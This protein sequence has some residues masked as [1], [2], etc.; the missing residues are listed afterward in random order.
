MNYDKER[1]S[2]I[3]TGIGFGFLIGLLS[4]VLSI[5][6]YIFSI[7]PSWIEPESNL[8][9]VGMTSDDGRMRPTSLRSL[10]VIAESPGVTSMGYLGFEQTLV[11]YGQSSQVR[12]ALLIDPKLIRKLGLEYLLQSEREFNQRV[13][14][15][16][17][18]HKEFSESSERI[19]YIGD[20][21]IP[22]QLS[23][24]FPSE[25]SGL[26]SW[27]PDIIISTQHAENLVRINFNIEN[28]SL[29]VVSR[30]KRQLSLENP[31]FFG[32]AELAPGFSPSDLNYS[33]TKG[34]NTPNINIVSGIENLTPYYYRGFELNPNEKES[35]K[36]QWWLMLYL[37]IFLCIAVCLSYVSQT[38]S[39]NIKNI[40][41]T[42][43][44][45]ALGAQRLHIIKENL[46]KDLPVIIQAITFGVVFS[47]IFISLYTYNIPAVQI[48]WSVILI[49]CVTGAA[50]VSLIVIVLSILS[51]LQT[52]TAKLFNRD[53][54]RLLDGKARSFYLINT[55]C[56]FIF[57]GVALVISVYLMLGLVNLILQKEFAPDVMSSSFARNP[58]F[59]SSVDINPQM[60][61]QYED[62]RFAIATMNVISP[63]SLMTQV[64]QNYPANRSDTVVNV[65]S[66]SKSF[67]EI[68]GREFIVGREPRGA[69][70]VV[71]RSASA[72]LGF[73]SPLEAINKRIHIDNS[74]ILG[75]E[76]MDQVVISGVVEDIPHY[77]YLASGQPFIYGPIELLKSVPS[78]S[79]FA[80]KDDLA[81]SEEL[82]LN[83]SQP[84]I[85][86]N[87]IGNGRVINQF[88]KASQEAI[89]IVLISIFISL[90]IS[91]FATLSLRKQNSAILNLESVVIGTKLAIG[92]SKTNAF[93]EFAKPL[94]MWSAFSVLFYIPISFFIT[95]LLFDSMILFQFFIACII[96]III[97][98][99]IGV[100]G[101]VM[102]FIQLVSRSPNSLIKG[103]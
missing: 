33:E 17:E 98:L 93:L 62:G 51:T 37:T 26:G 36:Q 79:I 90:I 100:I 8:T 73:E 96:A 65:K 34:T 24:T 78:V 11:R 9:T 71:A 32:L 13:F 42:K 80:G 27:S 87:V 60:I 58:K 86:W 67:F 97:N 31:A 54:S 47:I 64:S 49:A 28:V 84:S 19:L 39:R 85:A 77:G 101:I 81:R 53:K 22:L 25:L 41:A 50:L 102:P 69:E 57:V 55:V 95:S 75:F 46:R 44:R 88:F 38:I 103:Y 59:L 5:A 89:G 66:I 63:N 2:T 83:A 40:S 45:I 52:F 72:A 61:T 10:E 74:Y 68:L 91:T 48:K 30:L 7:Y 70:V 29:A 4:V 6:T 82:V 92:A 35:I 3:L 21:E 94:F 16:E 56:Q 15:S 99:C 14:I 43:L 20:S 18:I 1:A 76:N 23:G 12:T